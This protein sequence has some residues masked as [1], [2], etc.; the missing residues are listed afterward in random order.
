MFDNFRFAADDDL[1]DFGYEEE[2]LDVQPGANEYGPEDEDEDELTPPHPATTEHTP[3]S[4]PPPAS[5]APPKKKP[6]KKAT[7][8]PAPAPEA[9]AKVAPPKPT[10]AKAAPAKKAPAKKAPAKKKR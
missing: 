3:P 7:V 5:E 6:V 1:D 8:K 9:P 4:T 10:A 2:H